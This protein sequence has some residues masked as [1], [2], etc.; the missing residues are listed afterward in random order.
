MA[1]LGAPFTYQAPGA[2]ARLVGKRVNAQLL[3]EAAI[4]QEATRRAGTA[5]HA[6][7]PS[8]RLALLAALGGA[9]RLIAL[10]GLG[11]HER[12]GVV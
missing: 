5:Y 11:E 4:E 6:L 8:E 3:E 7:D 9:A 10:P 1:Q 12:A 2:A